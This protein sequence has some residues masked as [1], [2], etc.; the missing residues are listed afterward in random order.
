MG[1]NFSNLDGSNIAKVKKRENLGSS[2]LRFGGGVRATVVY[3]LLNKL[4]E[5]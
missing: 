4:I 3:Q 5:S 1:K 2:R